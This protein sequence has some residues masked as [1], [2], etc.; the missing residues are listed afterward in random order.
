ME[1]GR[2]VTVLAPQDFLQS[3]D[4]LAAAYVQAFWGGLDLVVHRG[5]S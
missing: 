3:K 5:T 2:L 4:P 1:A